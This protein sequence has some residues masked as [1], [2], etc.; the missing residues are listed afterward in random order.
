MPSIL[1]R[2]IAAAFVALIAVILAAPAILAQT[3]YTIGQRVLVL[4]V[5]STSPPEASIVQTLQAYEI[6]Y[7]VIVV[8][9]TGYSGNIPLLDASGNPKYSLIIAASAQLAYAGT[10]GV[11]ASALTT[12]QWDYIIQYEGKYRVRR[13]AVDDFPGV[14]TGTA[15]YNS[16]IGKTYNDTQMITINTTYSAPA[17]IQPS[18]AGNSSGLWHTPAIVSITTS[19]ITSVAPVLFF[20]PV[21]PNFPVQTSAAVHVTYTSGREQ[22]SLFFA[23]GSWSPT[24]S[25]LNHV[26]L[27]WGTRGLYQGFRRTYMLGQVDDLFLKT[28]T[29]TDATNTYRTTPEDL[30]NLYKWQESLNRRL[31]QGSSFKVE[32][33]FNGNGILEAAG[34]TELI[35]INTE[36]ATGINDSY[37]KPLG[38]GTS[39]W[40]STWASSWATTPTPLHADAMFDW[41]LTNT[42]TNMAPIF[43]VSHTFTHLNFDSATQSDV[44]NEIEMNVKMATV[45]SLDGKS[46]W[47]PNSMVTPQISG[48]FNG[49]VYTQLTQHGIVTIVGDNSRAS[50]V[51]TDLYGLWRSTAASSNYVGYAVIPRQPTEVYYDCSL[52]EENVGVYNGMYLAKLGSNSTWPQI[53]QREQDRLTTMLL[54]LRHDP[55]MFHQANLRNHD[56]PKVTINRIT[57]PWGLYEQWFENVFARYNQLVTWP[58]VTLKMDDLAQFY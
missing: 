26:W 46:Y 17:G 47:S 33:I 48:V 35:S 57:G 21:A 43:W 15:L 42:T 58:V 54:N 56:L 40:P 14:S 49:D 23:F 32:V 30:Q 55:H 27:A 45:L 8:Q 38:T 51:P 7:D 36:R 34:S 4:T 39:R 22:M 25:L 13:I 2:A 12:A 41:L 10:G 3:T 16:T 9:S 53:L 44:K 29:P 19:N 5:S 31:P 20:E 18:A 24:C 50:L 1:R 6:P 52:V 11:Y 37:V 28:E